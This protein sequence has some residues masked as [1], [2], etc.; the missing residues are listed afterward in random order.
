[1]WR[2]RPGAGTMLGACKTSGPNLPHPERRAVW[3]RYWSS[4]ALHS[5]SSSF[6]GN[7][8][9]AVARFCGLD[10]EPGMLAVERRGDAVATASSEMVRDG[11]RTD[12]GEVWKLYQTQLA[13]MIRALA[14]A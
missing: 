5:C 6:E 9:G 11:I 14:E 4:G 1:M 12:R 10:Y 2:K 3:P 7:H 8:D 13:P